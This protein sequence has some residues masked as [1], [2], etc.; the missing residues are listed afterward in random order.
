M[1]SKKKN[2]FK[3]N[4]K[5]NF[6]TKKQRGGRPH[7]YEAPKRKNHGTH[8]KFHDP[9][10]KVH[11]PNGPHPRVHPNNG[12]HQKSK[13]GFSPNKWFTPSTQTK[14]K[15]YLTQKVYQGNN[16]LRNLSK[17]ESNIKQ[18]QKAIESLEEKKKRITTGELQKWEVFKQKV[19]FGTDIHKLAGQI[20]TAQSKLAATEAA[21]R[22]SN[23]NTSQ[24]TVSK[25][26]IEDVL[27]SLKEVRKKHETD[28]QK[29]Q[30]NKFAQS[31]TPE[32]IRRTEERKQHLAELQKTL[33]ETYATA[34]PTPWYKPQSANQKQVKQ[35]LKEQIR[36]GAAELAH[37]NDFALSGLKLEQVQA[38]AKRGIFGNLKAKWAESQ[39][40]KAGSKLSLNATEAIRTAIRNAKNPEELAQTKKDKAQYLSEASYHSMN[41]EKLIE[42]AKRKAQVETSSRLTPAQKQE[43]T[44]I[45]ENTT[46]STKNITSAVS[47]LG[48]DRSTRI[49]VEKHLHN[50]LERRKA[51]VLLPTEKPLQAEQQVALSPNASVSPS[52]ETEYSNLNLLVPRVHEKTETIY[53]SAERQPPNASSTE[54]NIIIG[55]DV[56]TNP[57]QTE[58][59]QTNV[60]H[61]LPGVNQ[62]QQ[63]SA[64]PVQAA[65]LQQTLPPAV[66]PPR[67]IVNLQP[68]AESHT[69]ESVSDVVEQTY[70]NLPA[71]P[72]TNLQV[73]EPNLNQPAAA[74]APA[75]SASSAQTNLQVQAPNLT[76]PKVQ[77]SQIVPTLASAPIASAPTSSTS[78]KLASSPPA[79]SPLASTPA[80]SAPKIK[81]QEPTLLPTVL[82]GG[83]PGGPPAI[84]PPYTP[85][86]LHTPTPPHNV[87]PPPYQKQNSS[88]AQSVLNQPP[89]PTG[90]VDNKS[91]LGNQSTTLNPTLP[92]SAT[93][94]LHAQS[95]APTTEILPPASTTDL[96]APAPAPAQ[97]STP[98]SS[99]SILNKAR[100]FTTA[101]GQKLTS[102]SSASVAKQIRT[103]T[104][105]ALA[106]L[107]KATSNINRRTKKLNQRKNNLA[108]LKPQATQNI[109]DPNKKPEGWFQS[110]FSKTGR[111]ES[112][113]KQG[114][115]KI[116]K[117]QLQVVKMVNSALAKKQSNK[118][119]NP[120]AEI[121]FTNTD[122][123]ASEAASKFKNKN[124]KNPTQFEEV[125]KT[126]E[127]LKQ[128]LINN[129]DKAK[130][131]AFNEKQN[132]LSNPVELQRQIDEH[133]GSLTTQKSKLEQAQADKQ[134]AQSKLK[135]LV[136]KTAIAEQKAII[137]TAESDISSA[138]K[139]YKELQEA[140]PML[141][142]NLLQQKPS[143]FDANTNSSGKGF[144]VDYR[145]QLAK[146]EALQRAK[147]GDINIRAVMTNIQN[148]KT[149]SS[150]QNTLDQIKLNA[151]V[152]AIKVATETLAKTSLKE[153][154]A[155]KKAS[156]S[157]KANIQ[158]DF[159]P[160]K[161]KEIGNI[162][163]AHSSLSE[164]RQKLEASIKE[165]KAVDII[166][167]NLEL[168]RLEA[169]Q[170]PSNP[171]V[172]ETKSDPSTITIP[173]PST[174]PNTTPGTT[175]ETTPKPIYQNL[176]QATTQG[177]T[178]PGTASTQSVWQNFKNKASALKT[179]VGQK[180]KGTNSKTLKQKEIRSVLSNEL[181]EIE[182]IAS[183]TRKGKY[184]DFY[185]E[186]DLGKLEKSNP[187]NKSPEMQTIREKLEFIRETDRKSHRTGIPED[188]WNEYK[189]ARTTLAETAKAMAQKK[190]AEYSKIKQEDFEKS[191]KASLD[192]VELQR[193][194]EAHKETLKQQDKKIQDAKDLKEKLEAENVPFLQAVAA[195]KRV[196]KAIKKAKEEKEVLLMKDPTKNLYQTQQSSFDENSKKAQQG[197]F[198]GL[199]TSYSQERAKQKDIQKAKNEGINVAA[200]TQHLQNPTQT[201][202]ETEKNKIYADAEVIRAA[203]AKLESIG[204]VNGLN[205]EKA[206]K[207]AIES[208]QVLGPPKVREIES[209]IQ[210]PG[211]IS[212]IRKNLEATIKD[213]PTI[214]AIIKNLEYER[215]KTAASKIEG[216]KK[217]A[218]TI[219]GLKDEARELKRKE[220]L[221][222]AGI[223]NSEQTLPLAEEYQVVEPETVSDPVLT[224]V[225]T[226]VAS[227][228]VA[229]SV[230]PSSL[231]EPVAPAL[232]TPVSSPVEPV[233]STVVPVAS[234][235][236][237]LP[238]PVEPLPIPS[239][240]PLPPPRNPLPSTVLQSQ[241][242]SITIPP[243]PSSSL[244]TLPEKVITTP[245]LI[246]QP[247]PL[248]QQNASG[249]G[250]ETETEIANVATTGTQKIRTSSELNSAE[251]AN[252]LTK[253][254][255][256]ALKDWTGNSTP[257]KLK[258]LSELQK[259]IRHLGNLI[260]GINPKIYYTPKAA[261]TM[262]KEYQTKLQTEKSSLTGGSRNSSSKNHKKSK[263]S[264]KHNNSR[265]NH[266]HKNKK[267]SSSRK[268]I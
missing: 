90:F 187:D 134:L 49:L 219:E 254:L 69:N 255:N 51:G 99:P 118:I 5:N 131:K 197:F 40:R 56:S 130:Q 68:T 253:R 132:L 259:Y 172:V 60:L 166:M 76:Q 252:N 105:G 189:D 179:A 79:S 81:Q 135:F 143:N 175:P 117:G 242:P 31:R 27:A 260:P 91:H 6:K 258:K 167:K 212:E 158:R 201:T 200:V 55:T 62:P 128:Q 144:Y 104:L 37:S 108:A 123:S 33:K 251:S 2:N 162:I 137:K 4:Y 176:L 129:Y 75:S 35:R 94:D 102:K 67:Q 92:Q 232:I 215:L 150:S 45:K 142:L 42:A 249:T 98:K 261:L 65:P 188:I 155:I 115:E 59:Q 196:S 171:V 93:T 145:A 32:A 257:E 14:A 146:Q 85:Q 7:D 8:N 23:K 184:D 11:G 74:S 245:D 66:P 237:P 15:N 103:N 122:R 205:I 235:V 263:K 50:E 36:T 221:A 151:H 71:A 70:A 46:A 267:R 152:E 16:T 127:Q 30:N 83:P 157:V 223:S 233:P 12:P 140:N 1:S 9:H 138:N 97:S 95:P 218:S 89:Q 77:S 207:Q 22:A 186:R 250:H 112:K 265:T 147:N 203:S 247:D 25:K 264:K 116:A 34:Q 54:P 268:N 119:I 20:T 10:I 183:K 214:N 204:R 73:K 125:K 240:E 110:K 53:G 217:A 21:V 148:P 236:V 173:D 63:L 24:Y 52:A 230:E 220:K 211:P 96:P 13:W 48:M 29:A 17:H 227:I 266:N 159:D 41:P 238:S 224:Q 72:K 208:L 80:S 226:S 164:T 229:T 192:P 202:N 182:K 136:D 169:L 190:K 168:E 28:F 234:T 180:L 194:I 241:V 256:I 114:E 26:P 210:T 57:L 161:A 84:P 87:A 246:N 124:S 43:I 178:T 222:K 262:L 113:I 111:L 88:L 64:A 18:K 106:D 170:L 139:E 153:R 206:S 209:I 126:A 177:T 228:P 156:N 38:N 216:L 239:R 133:Q 3:K 160:I 78:S 107:N 86:E 225:S 243:V 199:K 185:I 244:I 163:E 149:T 82:S 100:A 44:K 101:I 61:T 39:A 47:K 121:Q 213:K 19:G 231:V 58:V 174:T 120:T 248:T 141:K 191:Q 109:T 193:Q 165:K 181:A 154:T 198:A 195:R